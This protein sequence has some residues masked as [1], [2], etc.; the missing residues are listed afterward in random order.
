MI[1]KKINMLTVLEKADFKQNNATMWKC[2]CE[3]GNIT[4]ARTTALNKGTKYSC[5]CYQRI[6]ASKPK[7]HGMSKTR[8]YKIHNSMKTRCFKETDPRYLLYG[9]KGITVCDEWSG[10]NGFINFYNWSIKNG[11]AD[12]LTIDRINSKGNYEPNNCRWVDWNVQANNT[13][14]NH[15]ITYKGETHTMG[16]WAKI[17]GIKYSTL[18]A[19]LWSGVPVEIAMENKKYK[20]GEIKKLINPRIEVE[21]E[22][23]NA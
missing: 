18:N 13:S 3:C 8:M 22:V 23:V 17:L 7:I 12:N 6:V 15:L 5:G 2:L 4:Y 10:K 9:A 21:I 14:R 16:E 19:R 1:G 11:Y 20:K